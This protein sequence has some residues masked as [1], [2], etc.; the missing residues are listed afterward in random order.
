M[1]LGCWS[2]GIHL[3]TKVSEKYKVGRECLS[4]WQRAAGEEQEEGSGKRV[5]GPIPPY[6]GGLDVDS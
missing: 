3:L 2:L 1:N 4:K 6:C 5:L